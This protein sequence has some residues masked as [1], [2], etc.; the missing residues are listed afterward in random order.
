[1]EQRLRFNKDA[2]AGRSS[3]YKL[4][5]TCLIQKSCE[6]EKTK[7]C[8]R[9]GAFIKVAR[10]LLR[11]LAV[12]ALL[13]MAAH[14]ISSRVKGRKVTVHVSRRHAHPRQRRVALDSDSSMLT[15]VM[16]GCDAAASW[17]SLGL[18]YSF[19]RSISRDLDIQM[20]LRS[21]ACY[22]DRD[23]Q[24]KPDSLFESSSMKYFKDVG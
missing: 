12:A 21:V 7:H 13:A 17:Q 10:T 18:Y 16:T 14:L 23:A 19:L 3:E 24:K 9:R 2:S 15:V 4:H 8:S 11:C 1:M 5:R 20:R 22:H 6:E